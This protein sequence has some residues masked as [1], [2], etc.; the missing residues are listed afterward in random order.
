MDAACRLT[1]RGLGRRH[2]VAR[3]HGKE[4]AGAGNL[5]KNP[6]W[7]APTGAFCIQESGSSV[8]LVELSQSGQNRLKV[9][10]IE[11]G[12]DLEVRDFSSA[13]PFVDGARANGQ[14]LGQFLLFDQGGIFGWSIHSVASF[15]V[16]TH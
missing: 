15:A 14:P 7:F 8:H 16:S 11:P 12:A 3:E 1:L 9:V 10:K 2:H 5:I 4:N 6:G 13:H